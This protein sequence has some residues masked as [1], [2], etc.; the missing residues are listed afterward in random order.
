[1]RIALFTESYYPVVN[2]VSAAVR[3][4]ACALSP[5]HQVV[6]YAPRFPGHVDQDLEVVRFH[7]FRA[8]SQPEY[9]LAWPWNAALFRDFCRRRFDVVHTHS[10]FTLGQVG[11][12]WARRCGLPVVNTYH[13]L[14]VEYAHYCTW[15]PTPAVR[16]WLRYMSQSHCNASDQVAVPSAPIREVLLEYGVRRP[17]TVV[18]TG[19]PPAETADV[20][21]PPRARLG[22]PD[23]AAIVLYAG[24]LA[25]EKNLELLFQAF[26]RVAVAAPR[27]HLLLAGSGPE[28]ARSR[29]RVEA[30][31]LAGR[32]T[33][34]GFLAPSFLRRCYAEAELLA[35]TSLTD[36]QGLVI[37][38]AKAAGLPVVAVDAY[39]PGTV[40][41]NG[42]D[43]CL[44]PNDPDAFAG[45]LL[46]L[47][48]DRLER[49]R[50][51][52]AAVQDAQRYTIE[53]TAA[54]YLQ[55]YE[56]A[57]PAQSAAS[58]ARLERI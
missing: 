7:S 38:E 53:A 13:T 5:E 12:R 56:A 29:A 57:S 9:P 34:A 28:V 50:L 30:A 47:L 32:V 58:A 23:D 31:G 24:R 6:I 42:I 46:R 22:I 39:G 36:T 3:W 45:S 4:L 26:E 48:G 20:G 51:S 44:V 33:F 11:R 52:D 54:A 15:A 18:P 49:R 25:R 41:R 1:M 8:P 21:P 14:Y 43:G 16:T 37:V 17:I 2:G 35:F 27:S 10:P 19:L 40:V 55:L